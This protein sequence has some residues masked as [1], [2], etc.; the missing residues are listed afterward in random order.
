MLARRWRP[1]FTFRGLWLDQKL[2]T[3]SLVDV[4][5]HVTGLRHVSSVIVDLLILIWSSPWRYRFPIDTVAFTRFL[6]VE[7]FP[8]AHEC[9]T[10]S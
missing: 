1:V 2:A 4:T 10:S 8:I 6:A 7:I 5:H 9:N 3:R